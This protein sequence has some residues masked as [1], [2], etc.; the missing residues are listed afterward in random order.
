MG[1]LSGLINKVRKGFGGED[2]DVPNELDDGYV[3]IDTESGKASRA[4]IIVKPY[5]LETFDDVKVVLDD[6]REGYTIA[7]VN[8]GPLK[9]RDLVELKRAVNKLKKTCEAIEGDIAGF[10]ENW[11]TI[12]PSFATIH[13]E[14]RIPKPAAGPRGPGMDSGAFEKY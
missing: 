8:I 1:L 5:V 12:V 2:Y 4:K 10:G 6:L 3:E 14:A 7:L 11:V 13:R 9:D